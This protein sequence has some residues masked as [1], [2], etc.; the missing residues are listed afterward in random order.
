[1]QTMRSILEQSGTALAQTVYEDT[2]LLDYEI[3][4][5]I[6]FTI[7]KANMEKRTWKKIKGYQDELVR[8]Y[9]AEEYQA[10]DRELAAVP[11]DDREQKA[12]LRVKKREMKTQIEKK[13]FADSFP[14]AKYGKEICVISYKSGVSA[15]DLEELTGRQENS[16]GDLLR[17]PWFLSDIDW[18]MD[19]AERLR[20]GESRKL[21]MEGGYC[22]L[23]TDEMLFHIFLENGEEHIFDFNTMQDLTNKEQEYVSSEIDTALYEYVQTHQTSIR[24]VTI[25]CEKDRITTD[26]YQQL[27]YLFVLAEYFHAR[28]VVTIPDRSYEK[29]FLQTFG[30][31]PDYILT[32]LH[33]QFMGHINRISDICIEW[34]NK[35]MSRFPNQETVIFHGR[36]EEFIEL[37]NKGRVKYLDAYAKKHLTTIRDGRRDA[38]MDYVCM[39]A[40]P[41]YRWGTT[42]VIEVN[43]LEEYPS[44]E[45]CRRIHKGAMHLHSM[46]FPQEPSGNG[47]TS[48]FYARRKYKKY[49][50]L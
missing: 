37:F 21:G 23:G 6:G 25:E 5:D 26:E 18:F 7:K 22:I 33:E 40:L 8:A 29:T 43:R 49:I 47:R 34:V 44:I 24:A 45:K 30:S 9:A 2:P 15:I 38:L 48:C 50:E 14:C 28:L 12:R 20:N 46:L 11:K 27:Y 19:T 1:M 39:P 31:L 3:P 42:D 35:L 4:I 10:L 36:D 32:G 17:H 13:A 41:F 16:F